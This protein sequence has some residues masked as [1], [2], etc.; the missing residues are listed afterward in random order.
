MVGEAADLLIEKFM[1]M[2]VNLDPDFVRIGV[3]I[4]D[5]GK[6]THTNEMY[7]PGS[8]HEP[9]GERILL[10]RG[11]APAIARCCLSHARWSDMEWTIEELTIALSDK[12]WKGK[13]VEELELQLIDRISHTLGAD[14]WDVFPELDLCFEAIASEGHN[15]LERS[16]AN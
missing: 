1:E 2:K 14:R 10:S 12:L 3:V 13:R 11:F 6:I 16:A 15:R 7:G 5:I 9:E 4:H 8:Q